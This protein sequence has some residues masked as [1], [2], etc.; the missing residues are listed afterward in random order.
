MDIFLAD[1]SVDY[2]IITAL[3]TRGFIVQ[4]MIDISPGMS[5]NDVLS[6]C[7]KTILFL[8]QKTKTLVS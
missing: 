3:N 7:V 1:E 6:Y 8:L 5:D 4:P 2:R